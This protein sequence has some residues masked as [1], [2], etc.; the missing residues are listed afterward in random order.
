MTQPGN[1]IRIQDYPTLE[2]GNTAFPGAEYSIE[3][4]AGK[5]S[6][7]LVL[8][9]CFTGAQLISDLLK[10][11]NAQYACAIS[12]PKAGYRELYVSPDRRQKLLNHIQELQWNIRNFGDP[13]CFTPMIVVTKAVTKTLSAGKHNVHALWDKETVTFPQGA[14]LAV[15]ATFRL[16]KPSLSG[17]VKFVPEESMEQGMLYAQADASS[18]FMFTVLCHPDFHVQF[19]RAA[20]NRLFPENVSPLVA[21]AC[22]SILQKQYAEDDGEQGWESYINLKQLAQFLEDRNFGHWSDD[23]FNPLEVATT[24]FS[25]RWPPGNDTDA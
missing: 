10:S 23:N 5:S 4:C 7:E 8:K 13:P 17:M 16:T 19:Q 21:T 2:E 24:L 12:S 18:D 15:H 3:H 25:Y 11:R 20:E 1:N 22:F 9:H 6:T 14:R